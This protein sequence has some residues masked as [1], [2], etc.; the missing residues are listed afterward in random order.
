M[1][2]EIK[3][4]I[5]CGII[6]TIGIVSISVFYNE[7]DMKRN[8]P[9][10]NEIADKSK[11]QK[12]PSILD[13]TGYINIPS[14]ELAE[15]LEGKVVLYDI[16]TYSCINC[17]R[18]LPYITTWDEKYRNEGLVIVG[19]HTPEFEFEKDKDSVLT[20]VQKFDINYPV[21]LDNEKEIWNAFQNKYWPRKYIADH[22]GYIRYD[23]IG[24][25]SYK[26][27][28]KVIQQLLQERSESLNIKTNTFELTTLDE[29]EHSTFRT[30]ELYFGYKFANGRNNLGNENGFKAEEVVEYN[31]PLETKQN[32]FYLDGKWN[33]SK[34]SME[35]VSDNGI[36]MLNYNAKQV[37]IVASNN[38]ELQ[39]FVDGAPVPDNMMG[40]DL[41]SQNKI[42]VSEPRLYNIINSDY[43]ESHELIISIKGS[44]FEIFTFTFG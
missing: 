21:V 19:I 25:G 16:W 17:I 30:P 2:T 8:T 27:T 41:T 5:I 3:T 6:I 1:K 40:S 42:L 22:D 15:T 10:N 26:E 33:N 23:H 13:A 32:Y 7:V 36:I 11:L 37:N 24:E 14:N 9:Y 18:T 43:S 29:F 35:L 38:A 44:E 28:E 39:I 4:A 20:A 12:V 31:I 34:D